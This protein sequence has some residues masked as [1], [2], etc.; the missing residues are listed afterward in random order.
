MKGQWFYLDGP[1]ALI[2]DEGMTIGRIERKHG[3]VAAAAPELL[4][5]C[6]ELLPELKCACDESF[7]SRGR[8][9]PNSLCHHYD[10]VLTAVERT[11]RPE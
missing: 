1:E 11:R 7:T 9:E 4:K 6:E 3:Y 8:H 5:V 10:A 2:D